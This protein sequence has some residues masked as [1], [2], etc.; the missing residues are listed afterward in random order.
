MKRARLLWC[1]L[2]VVLVLA[3]LPSHAQERGEDVAAVYKNY[4]K[5]LIDKDY[6]GAWDGLTG[7]SKMVIAK[8]IAQEAKARIEPERVLQ[9]LNDNEKGIRDTYFEAF[10][11]NIRELLDEIYNRGIYTVKSVSGQYAIV[12]IEVQKDPK[13]FGMAKQDGKWK[14]NFFKDLAVSK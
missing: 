2:F 8:L 4:F 10:R 12:N 3:A 9:M 5:M 7:E 13:D 1:M 11:E 6:T 14:V